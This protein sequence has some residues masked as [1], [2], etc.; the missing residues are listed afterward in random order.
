MDDDNLADILDAYSSEEAV[1]S[2]RRE[3]HEST[4][5]KIDRGELVKDYP[6]PQRDL[7]LHNHTVP[8]ALFE[9]DR[10]IRQAINHRLR[11]V[12]LITGR[13]L[14][15]KNMISVLPQEIEKKLAELRKEGRILAFK[16]E[17]SGGSFAVYLVS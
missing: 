5:P 9:V 11:T 15:S 6:V 10:F 1:R 16:R 17:K 12:R 3:K 2:A 4:E 8:E 14:H 13:G 7:D